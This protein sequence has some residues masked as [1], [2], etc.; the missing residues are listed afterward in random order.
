MTGGVVSR[1]VMVWM[2]LLLLPQA[3]VA[4]QV[5]ATTLVPPQLVV[6]ESL[7]LRLTELQPSCAVATPVKL[8]LVLAGHS[9]TTFVGQVMTGG[10]VSSTVIVCTQRVLLRP[11]SVAFQGGAMTLLP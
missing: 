7:K 1:T 10:V 3:S 5:R 4:V 11:A 6:I 8:V 9:S 2:Q